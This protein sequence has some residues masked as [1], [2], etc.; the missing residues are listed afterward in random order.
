M[1]W[2]DWLNIYAPDHD[3]LGT[4]FAKTP[5]NCTWKITMKLLYFFYHILRA[6]NP[7][8]P[9][10]RWTWYDCW[11]MAERDT[12]NPVREYGVFNDEGLIEDGFFSHNEACEAISLRYPVKIFTL[13]EFV[14]NILGK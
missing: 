4:Y 9:K 7:L 14:I 11:E 3:E 1:D 12:W 10:P 8:S 6:C 2:Y 5:I 13:L